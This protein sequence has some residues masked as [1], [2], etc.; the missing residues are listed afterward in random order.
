MSDARWLDQQGSFM[1]TVAAQPVFRLLGVKD[2][3]V[4]DDYNT[5]QMPPVNQELLDGNLAWRQYD[6]G[7][8]DAPNVKYFIARADKMI[9][10]PQ[11]N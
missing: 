7:H 9:G 11:A 1:T 3:G 4:P 10:H 8:T 2:I 5:A 6:G